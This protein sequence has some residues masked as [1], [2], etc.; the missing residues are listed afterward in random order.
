VIDKNFLETYII[1]SGKNA[2]LTFAQV[3]RS[4]I[5]SEMKKGITLCWIWPGPLFPN[6]YGRFNI[7]GKSALAHRI[8]LMLE[9]LD[10]KSLVACHRCDIKSCVNPSHLLLGS[11]KENMQDCLR[12]GRFN[13]P[14]GDKS[15][16]TKFSNEDVK[17][18]F[19]LREKN[20]LC[21]EISAK[22]NVSAACISRIL[23]GS[24]WK[25]FKKDR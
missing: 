1:P 6:G 20:L 12:K 7:R 24:R 22:Y 21:K 5:Q 8:S 16:K 18:I 3:F 25:N 10:T 23:A 4:F 2:K 11:Q 14:C 13:A 19:K 15:G 9:G 17:N